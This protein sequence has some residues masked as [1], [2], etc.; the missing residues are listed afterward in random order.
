MACTT[1]RCHE[2]VSDLV[3]GKSPPR[4]P[5]TSNCLIK[6]LLGTAVSMVILNVCQ[7]SVSNMNITPAANFQP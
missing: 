2:R 7:S 5:E 1:R 4:G 3:G 6:E